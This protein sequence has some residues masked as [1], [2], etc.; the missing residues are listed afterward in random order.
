[1]DIRN[2]SSNYGL[3]YVP[4]NISFQTAMMRNYY[5]I[6]LRDLTSSTDGGNQLLSFSHNF[7]WDRAFSLRWDFTNNLSMT[8]T[9]V[10]MPVSKEPNVQVNKKLNPD[11]LSGMEGFRKAKY[12]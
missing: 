3:N 6:K 8:F 10:R 4:S 11:D 7:L 5:E 2:I 12:P 9:P 1:M